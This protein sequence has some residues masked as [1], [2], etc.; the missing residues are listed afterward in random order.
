ML[1][2]EEFQEMQNDLHYCDSFGFS[3]E[4]AEKFS[5][6]AAVDEDFKNYLLRHLEKF[7]RKAWILGILSAS[8]VYKAPPRAKQEAGVNSV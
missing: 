5:K 4:K 3:E 2:K 6:I 7:Q 8:Q 1:S